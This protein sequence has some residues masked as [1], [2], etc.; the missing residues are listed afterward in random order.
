MSL[1]FFISDI[2]SILPSIISGAEIV[3]VVL[4][5]ETTGPILLNA[6]ASQD[7]Y[8]AGSFLMF[9]ATLT[10]IGVLISDIALAMLVAMIAVSRGVRS[11]ERIN[12]VLVPTL[13]VIVLLSVVRA[14]TLPGSE[15]GIAYLL[16]PQWS[17]LAEPKVWLEAL[18]QNAWDTGAGWG[19]ILTYA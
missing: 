3:A 16:S 18:T 5:L 19:L 4:S 17:Q 7:M 15:A 8:L 11:I 10:V 6:L 12:R 1:N 14:V 9:L 2:G 13:L